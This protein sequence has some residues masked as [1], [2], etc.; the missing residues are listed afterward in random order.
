MRDLAM[1][2]S[3]WH[4]RR[5]NGV[6]R[7]RHVCTAGTVVSDHEGPISR[8]RT[9]G[10]ENPEVD[11][12]IPVSRPLIL[13]K[14][15]QFASYLGKNDFKT[16]HGWLDGFKSRKQ[17]V[18]KSVCG[19]SGDVDVQV[20][21]EWKTDL[22]T[23]DK[24]VTFK[25]EELQWWWLV[26]ENI[27]T[28]NEDK[29]VKIDLLQASRMCNRAWEIVKSKTIAN[30]SKE[31]GFTQQRKENGIPEFVTMDDEVV[32]CGEQ[33]D[34]E[35]AAGGVSSMVQSS[36]SSDEENELSE[37]P[38]Q[39]LPT[40]IETMEYIHELWRYFEAQQNVSDTVCK[41]PNILEDSLV[42]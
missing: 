22:C 32:V 7:G 13:A 14:A 4:R 29:K 27:L 20:A 31:A 37:L 35:I 17:I 40:S 41:S 6:L 34:A 16:S 2:R 1:V 12:K 30:C 19:E 10:P 42:A 9:R 23:P 33:A 38:V 39:P 21:N 8:K 24:T 28:A 15:E 18:F 36:G 25:G 5:C 26:V 11:Q 3:G